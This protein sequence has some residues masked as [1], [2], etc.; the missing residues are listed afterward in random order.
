MKVKTELYTIK[1]VNEIDDVC[2]L[3]ISSEY[4]I[5]VIKKK[6]EQWRK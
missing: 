2:K 1:L 5:W 3:N 4:K 6:I